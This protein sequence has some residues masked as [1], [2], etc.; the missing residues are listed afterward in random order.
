MTSI[1]TNVGAMV[2]LQ[3]LNATT[4]DLNETQ[5]RIATGLKVASAKDDGATFAIAQKM[6]RDVASYGVVSES[7]DRVTSTVDVA[8]AAG[9]GISDLLVEMKEKA[10]AASDESIDSA[11]RSALN[12][13]FTALRDQ[14]TTIVENATF[15]GVNIVDGSLSSLTALANTSG[16]STISVGSEDLSLSG[17][18]ITITASTQ[19]NTQSAAAS[20]VSSLDS[21]I[22]AVNNSL[23]RLGT[24][25]RKLE[26]HSEFVSKLSDSL[27]SG[28]GNLVDADLAQESAR[29]Q[30]LQVQ[31]QLGSQAL[32]IAN[33]A[34]SSVLALF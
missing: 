20:V 13:D 16:S 22:E 32:S 12:E 23:A 7:L 30:A 24:G 19:I 29:L 11:S 9:E 5:N 18:T 8:L 2:A 4:R 15:N 26:V 1:N 31:Q 10:L 33:R 21:S 3:N 17:S 28:I 25:S 27:K 14:I 6:R 34:P